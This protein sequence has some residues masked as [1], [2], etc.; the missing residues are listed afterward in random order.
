MVEWYT[1]TIEGKQSFSRELD[2]KSNSENEYEVNVDFVWKGI[3]KE[4]QN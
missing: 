2:C 3:T 1:K 4:D